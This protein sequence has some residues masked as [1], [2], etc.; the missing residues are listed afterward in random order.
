MRRSIAALVVLVVAAACAS[1]HTSQQTA[2][3]P[4]P[5]VVIIQRTNIGESIGT[6]P[7]GINVRYEFQITNKAAVPI[8]LKRIEFDALAGGGFDVRARSRP[9][10]TTIAPGSL[11]SVDFFTDVYIDPR[12]YSSQAPV[13]VRAVLLFDSP[14]GSLQTV[15]Q[16]RVSANSG[17]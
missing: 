1:G 8:T 3:I 12:T 13:G 14:E 7:T 4:K 6:M 5:E 15:V 11:G 10:D 2:N 17:D 16:Q 9:F